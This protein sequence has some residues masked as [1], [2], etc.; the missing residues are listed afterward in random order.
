M[1]DNGIAM[2]RA[3]LRSALAALA[4]LTGGPALAEAPVLVELYTSQ[5]CST[6]PPAD[7][8]LRELA[9]RD[10]VVALGLHVDYWDYLGWT[11]PYASPAHTQRQRAYSHAH[12]EKMVYTPQMVID[13]VVRM[14]GNRIAAVRRA[15]AERHLR[16]EEAPELT[17]SREGGRIRVVLT[18]GGAAPGP[19][20]VMV[21][22]YVPQRQTYVEAG[23]NA[24]H[25]LTYVNVVSSLV[26][27]GRWD[28]ASRA[29]LTVEAPDGPVAVFLQHPRMGEVI[30]AAKLP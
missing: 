20:D 27:V 4:L 22:A 30:G 9:G 10:D 23:E 11:D 28:G 18:P 19:V 3:V 7:E 8:L 5:G 21:A 29:E 24:G 25:D 1:P 2:T 6:C 26:R 13:G 16:H 12:G 17:L 15:V 14:P